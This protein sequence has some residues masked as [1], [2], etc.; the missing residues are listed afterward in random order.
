MTKR[1]HILTAGEKRMPVSGMKVSQAIREA[2]RWWNKTGR[3]HARAAR[4]R[5]DDGIKDDEEIMA[6][7]GIL[8]GK[9]FDECQIIEQN[10]IVKSWHHAWCCEELGIDMEE[11]LR[12]SHEEMMIVGLDGKTLGSRS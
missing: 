1:V 7:S 8:A 2:R 3:D 5:K 4:D 6:M 9:M 11:F 12:R 10:E